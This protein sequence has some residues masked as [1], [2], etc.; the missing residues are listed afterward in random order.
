MYKF[1]DS[2][3]IQAELIHSVPINNRQIPYRKRFQT[4]IT[5]EV[6][7]TKAVIQRVE[8]YGSDL[9]EKLGGY[10]SFLAIF[11]VLFEIPN[12]PQLYVVSDMITQSA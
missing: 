5:Y 10:W 12:N 3:N 6:E 1:G 8:T 2:K 9:L 4:A 7:K 11:L